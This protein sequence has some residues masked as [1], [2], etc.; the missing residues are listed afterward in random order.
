MNIF[1]TY[2]TQDHKKVPRK[3]K[4][5]ETL[6]YTLYWPLARGK[7]MIPTPE[8]VNEVSNFWAVYPTE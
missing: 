2:Y 8:T 7:L 3:E 6:L 4:K 5:Y 1:F